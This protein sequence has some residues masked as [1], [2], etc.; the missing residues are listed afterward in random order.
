MFLYVPPKKSP[1]NQNVNMIRPLFRPT[2]DSNAIQLSRYISWIEQLS[3]HQTFFQTQTTTRGPMQLW[4]QPNQ[5][6]SLCLR[7]LKQEYS[8][9]SCSSCLKNVCDEALLALSMSR[10]SMLLNLY[11]TKSLFMHALSK[12]QPSSSLYFGDMASHFLLL[13]SERRSCIYKRRGK[14]QPEL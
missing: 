4:T 11:E 9:S 5:L 3:C 8:T 1:K 13:G 12:K 14:R 2:H 7:P 10:R 6:K